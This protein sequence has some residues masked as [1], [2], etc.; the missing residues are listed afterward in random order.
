MKFGTFILIALGL[1]A[2]TA[3]LSLAYEELEKCF[4]AAKEKMSEVRRTVDAA[5]HQPIRWLWDAACQL[6]RDVQPRQGKGDREPSPPAFVICSTVVL[7][8]AVL[9]DAI[10][11]MLYTQAR[12]ADISN[13]DPTLS[14]QLF[15]V[16]GGLVFAASFLVYGLI[17]ADLEGIAGHSVFFGHYDDAKRKR[18]TRWVMIGAGIL[19]ASTILLSI[20]A[21]EMQQ[22]T[23]DELTLYGFSITFFVGSIGAILLGCLALP[24]FIALVGA[25]LLVALTLPFLLARIVFFLLWLIPAIV[26]WLCDLVLVRFLAKVAHLIWHRKPRQEPPSGTSSSPQD[27]TTAPPPIDLEAAR[28]AAQPTEP[29][30]EDRVARIGE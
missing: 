12:L 15:G 21:T 7:G 1:I 9:V 25:C 18:M 11:D 28:A 10:A 22:G 5:L 20:L 24:Q 13:T 3:I 23:T 30:Q 19:L 2:I 17:W 14:G 8:Q 27:P 26:L 6:V 4:T 16:L 29:Q